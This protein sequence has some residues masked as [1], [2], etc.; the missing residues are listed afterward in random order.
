M[1]R[2]NILIKLVMYIVPDVQTA[3]REMG[4]YKN[5]SKTVFDFYLEIWGIDGGEAFGQKGD[6]LWEVP[7]WQFVEFDQ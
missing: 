1:I 6:Y 4:N 3:L 7:L 2:Q 5:W